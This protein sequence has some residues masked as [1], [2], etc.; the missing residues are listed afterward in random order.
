MFLG[1]LPEPVETSGKTLRAKGLQAPRFTHTQTPDPPKAL[2]EE[3]G[4]LPGLSPQAKVSSGGRF[5]AIHWAQSTRTTRTKPNR[6]RHGQT[7][8][9]S[10]NKRPENHP[11]SF[12]G[13]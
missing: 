1:N 12:L 3:E 5:G 7:E 11:L 13:A 10:E 2:F 4:A 8:P 6:N 9:D